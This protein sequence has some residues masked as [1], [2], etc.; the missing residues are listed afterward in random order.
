MKENEFVLLIGPGT[1]LVKI[2][3]RKLNTEHGNIDLFELEK[4]N[5]G[6]KIKTHTGKEFMIIKPNVLDILM[7][8][9]RRL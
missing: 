6:D 5:F 9:A 3:D 1:Y 2:S 4:K 7:K 8:K